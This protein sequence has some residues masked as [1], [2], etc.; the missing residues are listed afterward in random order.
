MVP[1]SCACG[2]PPTDYSG[3]LTI[4]DEILKRVVE[5]PPHPQHLRFLLANTAVSDAAADM[6][7]VGQWLEIDRYALALTREL[8]ADCRADYERY[9]FHRV[10]QALQTFCSE[11]LGAS[12]WIS[13]RTGLHHGAGLRCPPFGPIGPVAHSSG[14]RPADGAD[15]LFHRRG[16]WAIVSGKADDSIML[17]RW[18]DLP[19]PPGEGDLLAKWGS[20]GGS[21]AR[22]P[23]PGR[24]SAEAGKIGSSLQAE[25][26]STVPAKPTMLASLAT[27]SEVR[28]HRL[29]GDGG[30]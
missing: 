9:E 10:V 22:S 30:R 1:T 8:Q 6:L 17:Q 20:P 3:E 23:S 24:N 19:K 7:P 5:I 21:A 26:A 2:R 28:P 27:T 4:S 15:P 29:Q 12:T 11:D 25:V 18:H 16:I 14:L 13:S